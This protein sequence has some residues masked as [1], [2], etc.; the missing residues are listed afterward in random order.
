M[1][2]KKCNKTFKITDTDQRFYNKIEVSE[3]VYCPDCRMQKRLAFRN[4]RN[5]YNHECTKCHDKII[6]Q[7]HPDSQLKV[8]CHDCYWQDDW[9][10]QDYARDFD[11]S[12]TFS[13]QF[14]ELL[15]E[16]PKMAMINTESENSEYTHLAARNKDCY[17]LIESSDNEKCLYSYWIQKST[18]CVD[19][20]YA[21]E[22]ELCYEC[23]NINNCYNLNSSQNCNDCSDSSYLLNCKSCKDC[24]ACVNLVSAQY[25]IFNKLYS[26][27]EYNIKIKE[28]NSVNNETKIQNFFIKHP[29]KFAEV[30]KI[31]NCTGNY[32]SS[33]RDCQNVF[34]SYEADNCSYAEH[35]W[36][37]ATDCM[38]VST[39]GI[40]AQLVYDSINCALGVNDIKFSNQCWHKCADLEYCFYCGGLSNGF[41]CTAIKQGKNLILNK[42]YNNKEFEQLRKKIN[43]HM[44]ETGEWGT[45]IE[46]KHSLF[47]YQETIANELYPLKKEEAVLNNFNYK[48]IKKTKINIQNS[49]IKECKFCQ[50]PFKIIK[51]EQEFYSSKKLDQPLACPDCRHARRIKLRGPNKLWHRECMKPDCNNNFETTYSPERKELIYCERCYNQEIV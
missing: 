23:D 26:K 33:A 47:S 9:H 11:F 41:G 40:N 14:F 39:V 42:S 45:F 3:P 4:E 36:R 46:P 32:I 31:E 6:S 43:L 8:Y 48:E 10:G 44:K 15:L 7:Y 21:H 22:C 34:H 18:D 24:Y 25:C 51:Q 19:V 16:T 38:D 49:D 2:C 17:M 30:K 28:L 5:F 37:N 29:R 50:G 12:K 27:E 1:Q 20:N 13:E 35:V